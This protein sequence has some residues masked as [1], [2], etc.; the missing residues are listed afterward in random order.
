M[1]DSQP[2]Q[3]EYDSKMPVFE[4]ERLERI[5]RNRQ[6]LCDLGLDKPP[7]L[8]LANAGKSKRQKRVKTAEVLEPTRRS[9][10]LQHQQPEGWQM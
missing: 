1:P 6:I 10:R 2:V 8:L 3:Q 7:E 5:K 9:R 4:R